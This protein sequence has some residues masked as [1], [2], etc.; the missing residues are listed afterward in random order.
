M[1]DDRTK[2]SMRELIEEA[3]RRGIASAE[4]MDRAALI[5]ALAE[6]DRRSPGLSPLARA[7]RFLGAVTGAVRSVMDPARPVAEVDRSRRPSAPVEPV[8]HPSPA[9]STTTAVVE[10]T[11]AVASAVPPAA[12]DLSAIEEAPA[13]RLEPT[14]TGLRVIAKD[15]RSWLVWRAPSARLEAVGKPASELTLRLVSIGCAIGELDADVIVSTEDHA[16]GGL[17]GAREL[18][19][20]DLRQRRVA[21]IGVGRGEGFVA[22]AHARIA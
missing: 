19:A 12:P 16:I 14:T 15:G 10:T 3:E 2:K 1:S 5:R 4:W 7:R 17:E 22:L 11:A 6:A 21:A 18:P 20:N 9:E 13:P 8:V